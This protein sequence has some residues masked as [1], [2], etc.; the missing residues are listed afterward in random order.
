[1]RSTFFL[2]QVQNQ[3]HGNLLVLHENS[4]VDWI[5]HGVSFNPELVPCK[6]SGC[7]EWKKWEG[8]NGCHYLIK[9][10]KYVRS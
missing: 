6:R 9:A 8:R 1:M 5:N 2:Q 3:V 4:I 10:G 7:P